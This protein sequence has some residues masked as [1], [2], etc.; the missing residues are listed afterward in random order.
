MTRYRWVAIVIS[1]S[2]AIISVTIMIVEGSITAEAWAL[3]L[4][5]PVPVGFAITWNRSEPHSRTDM[6]SDWSVDSD[7]GESGDVGDPAEAGFDIPVL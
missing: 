1:A 6:V 2:L 3:L 4:L 5:T 7:E